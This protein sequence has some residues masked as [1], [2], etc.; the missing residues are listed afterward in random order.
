MAIHQDRH[1]RAG[2][3]RFAKLP[4][5]C[6]EGRRRRRRRKAERR[7]EKAYCRA[8]AELFQGDDYI[9]MFKRREIY[10]HLSN[11]A[12]RMANC[13]NIATRH[14]GQDV[15][16]L[17][18]AATFGQRLARP[19]QGL[20]WQLVPSAAAGQGSDRRLPHTSNWVSSSACSASSPSASMSAGSAKTAFCWPVAG[21]LQGLGRHPGKT[22][23]SPKVRRWRPASP[24]TARPLPRHCAARHPQPSSSSPPAGAGGFYRIARGPA[25]P[26]SW[27]PSTTGRRQVGLI[28]SLDLGGD[29][30]TDL[31]PSRNATP[32]AGGLERA[33]PVRF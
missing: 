32:A 1:R 13:A 12:D 28:D 6:P 33:A 26:S 20:G 16:T 31:P 18:P 7:V 5:T 27:L 17:P 25:S 9:H 21:L 3:A 23:G 10:R 19:L 2:Y 30:E 24:P 8:I 22:A 4:P 29:A 11:A 14:R 15:L